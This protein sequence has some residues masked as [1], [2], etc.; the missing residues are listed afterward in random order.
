MRNIVLK[1]YQEIKNLAPIIAEVE[2]LYNSPLGFTLSNG[3]YCSSGPTAEGFRDCFKFDPK[4]KIMKVE[5][6]IS[7][8]ECAII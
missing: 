8:E 7:K 2:C 5:M 1:T 6:I 4:K 3:E